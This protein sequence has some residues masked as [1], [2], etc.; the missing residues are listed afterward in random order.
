VRQPQYTHDAGCGDDACD[1]MHHVTLQRAVGGA[2]DGLFDELGYANA[3]P[4]LSGTDMP[5]T[6]NRRLEEI[7]V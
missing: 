3:T 6:S 7:A 4:M 5:E 2:D 1:S